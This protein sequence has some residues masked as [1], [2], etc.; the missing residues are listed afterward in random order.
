MNM[1]RVLLLEKRLAKIEKFI[2]EKIDRLNANGQESDTYRIWQYLMDNGK[3]VLRGSIRKDF[4]DIN[5]NVFSKILR[6]G[7]K[8]GCF[9]KAGTTG[10]RL[11]ANS[12]Y[13]WN[14]P[15]MVKEPE[16]EV[17]SEMV[18]EPE[19]EVNSTPVI[20]D[21]SVSNKGPVRYKP[22]DF[23]KG[24]IKV[25][26]TNKAKSDVLE[27][28][29]DDWTA[30]EVLDNLQKSKRESIAALFSSSYDKFRKAII[31]YGIDKFSRGLKAE[32]KR[33][34]VVVPK[35]IDP[36]ESQYIDDYSDEFTGVDGYDNKSFDYYN[37]DDLRW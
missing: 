1:N 28:L 16:S 32:L 24:I 9:I 11:T 37:N 17:E 5:S 34:G 21:T 10:E 29:E 7:L 20:S 2:N 31:A 27:Q 26:K 23:A 33:Q 15:E 30:I 25:L 22:S 12:N 3:P 8:E 13:E 35:Y 14:E 36:D 4:S 18:K 6:D 19:L